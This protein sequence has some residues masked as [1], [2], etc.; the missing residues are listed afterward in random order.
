MQVFSIQMLLYFSQIASRVCTLVVFILIVQVVYMDVFLL[1]KM[2]FLKCSAAQKIE[3]QFQHCL[4]QSALFIIQEN[5]KIIN[6][7]ISDTSD[8]NH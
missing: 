3:I 7:I 5:Y 6:F 1:H 2:S 8:P 4:F